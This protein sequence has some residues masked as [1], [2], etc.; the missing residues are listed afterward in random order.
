MKDL[1]PW[2]KKSEELMSSRREDT[3]LDMLE[4]R[5][6]RLFEDFFEDFGPAWNRGSLLRRGEGWAEELPSFEVSES[7]EE[8]CVKAELPGMDEKDIDVS[9]EGRELTI[10][11][12]KKREHEDKHRDY[13][14]S[15]VSYGEFC[16]SIQ[17]PEGIDRDKVKAEFKKGV[18]TL[19]LPKTEEGRVQRKR[20]DVKA[21]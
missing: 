8:F 14:V 19:T 6:N 3:S 16:R 12:E 21:A 7:D 10:R 15:E 5:M 9:L 4:R 1:I 11:G 13:Y 2:R 20:I 17:L 18:L